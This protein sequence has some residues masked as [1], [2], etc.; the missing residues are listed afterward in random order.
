MSRRDGHDNFVDQLYAGFNRNSS[1]NRKQI[2]E[3]MYVRVLTEICANR[4]KWEGLPN[5]VDKR[6]IELNLFRQALVVFFWDAEYERYFALR[7]AGAG[8]WN[9]YDNPTTFRVIGNTMISRTLHPG[10]YTLWENGQA[11]A[12]PGNCVPIWANTLRTPDWDI[13]YLQS[14]KLAEV[15]RTIEIT[16]QQMRTPWL[17]GV[18]DNERLSFINFMRQHQEGEPYI[19]GTNTLTDDIEKKIKQFPLTIDREVV[20]NLQIAKSKIWNETMTLIGINNANQDKRERLVADEVSANDSQVEAVRNSALSARQYACEQINLRYP[21]LT[22]SC[23]WNETTP[24]LE[25]STNTTVK[26]E[27]DPG[28]DVN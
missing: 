10:K 7:G 27:A 15:E 13:I 14:S 26:Q 3:R 24:L 18:D 4:F 8:K 5:D 28:Q 19:F 12:M 9:M 25:S 11:V 16:L 23:E 1:R 20:L 21:E 17:F 6:F 2:Y 22:V